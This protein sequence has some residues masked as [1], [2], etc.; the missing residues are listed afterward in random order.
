MED[1][2]VAQVL[3][4]L[5]TTVSITW[6]LQSYLVWRAIDAPGKSVGLARALLLMTGLAVASICCAVGAL[7][8]LAV[9]GATASFALL[10][11]LSMWTTGIFLFGVGGYYTLVLIDYSRRNP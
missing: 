4:A 9:W 2:P 11:N 6:G 7:H 8:I 3:S 5:I 10:Y 1:P